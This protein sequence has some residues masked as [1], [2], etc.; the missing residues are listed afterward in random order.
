M[1]TAIVTLNSSKDLEEFY[2]KYAEYMLYNYP[3]FMI[4]PYIEQ[5]QIP[6]LMNFNPNVIQSMP[7]VIRPMPAVGVL[8]SGLVSQG[9]PG[10]NQFNPNM[11]INQFSNLSLS[12]RNINIIYNINILIFRS[13][14]FCSY[15]NSSSSN[16]SSAYY[17]CRSK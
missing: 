1:R 9:H 11:F 3:K 6:N 17:L 16:S 2:K 12:K 8:Q 10:S 14:S 15:P 5:V 7:G 13:S 4:Q